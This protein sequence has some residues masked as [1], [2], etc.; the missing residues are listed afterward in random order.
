MKQF[1]ISSANKLAEPFTKSSASSKS[2]LIGEDYDLFQLPKQK[3]QKVAQ[4][5]HSIR[6]NSASRPDAY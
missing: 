5:G 2:I 1:R 4:K 6:I 3:Q